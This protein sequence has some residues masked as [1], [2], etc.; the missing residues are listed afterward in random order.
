MGKILGSI[1]SALSGLLDIEGGQVLVDELREQEGVSLVYDIGQL[2]ESETLRVATRSF[3]TGA[4][5][6]S[7][8]STATLTGMPQM[9][10]I[11]GIDVLTDDA[12]RVS[13]VTLFG[14]D[15]GLADAAATN[16]RCQLMWNWV[17]AG[18][19]LPRP[20]GYSAGD[21]ALSTILLAEAADNNLLGPTPIF[22][23]QQGVA[24]RSGHENLIIGVLSTGFGAG[25]VRVTGHVT[26][27]FP[28]TLGGFGVNLLPKS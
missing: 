19:T 18:R 10:R 1:P 4:I 9:C 8:T 2:I 6:Q 12:T 3:D 14:D 20:G 25:T 22:F 15:I 16:A 11:L 7:I 24:Q 28:T 23:N 27:L 21:A 26:L 17:N 13:Q 5:N